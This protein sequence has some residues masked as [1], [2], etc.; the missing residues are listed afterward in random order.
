MSQMSLVDVS[1]LHRLH[2][3]DCPFLCRQQ[4]EGC[5]VQIRANI[6]SHLW[7]LFYIRLYL[8]H[9]HTKIKQCLR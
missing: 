5:F 3:R 6:S 1:T 2:F 4:K 9:V 7:I 8:I